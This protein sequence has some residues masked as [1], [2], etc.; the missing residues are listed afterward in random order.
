MKMLLASLTLLSNIS[1]AGA[2]VERVKDIEPT[3]QL[4]ITE[5]PCKVFSINGATD[6]F[7]AYI[8]DTS[9]GKKAEGCWQLERG[10]IVH[11]DIVVPDEKSYYSYRYPASDFQLRPNL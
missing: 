4:T 8:V 5:E 7:R 2:P 6:V 3:V 1:Y 9:I 11:I 10:S